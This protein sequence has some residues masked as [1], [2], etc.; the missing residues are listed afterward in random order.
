MGRVF[1]HLVWATRFRRRSITA[2]VR[3][4]LY[5]CMQAECARLGLE[6]VAIGGV[7][8]HVHLLVR[9]PTTVAIAEAVR[10]I[11]G[12]SSHLVNHEIAPRPRFRWQGGY[13]AFSVSERYVP[14]VR[15]YI[16]NQ[17]AHHRRGTVHRAYEES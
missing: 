2:A 17:E 5:A 16:L 3:P 11:K 7:E 1:V 12:S 14:R 6:L 13:A 8:D 9:L 10:R 15:G 4:R